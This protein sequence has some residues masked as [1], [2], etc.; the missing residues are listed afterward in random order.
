MEL[1]ILNRTPTELKI[2][3]KGESHTLCNLLESI[4][5]EDGDVEAAGYNIPHP[6]ISNP[7]IYIRTNGKKKPEEALKEAAEKILQKGKELREEFNKTA[8]DWQKEKK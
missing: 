6:L 4:L 3:V 2:E 8:E 7:I 5:L 1:K